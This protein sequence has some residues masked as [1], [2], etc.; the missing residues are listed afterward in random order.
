MKDTT[1]LVK[2]KGHVECGTKSKC[3]LQIFGE[4]ATNQLQTKNGKK[5]MMKRKRRPISHPGT[6]PR[7]MA[8]SEMAE[9]TPRAISLAIQTLK[10]REKFVATKM[11]KHL[12][13]LPPII[14]VQRK[15]D[16]SLQW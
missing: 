14:M 11:G 10:F 8:T 4:T 9:Q 3:F 2:T 15:M 16:V 5:L 1:N 13:D 6:G 7:N 12:Q